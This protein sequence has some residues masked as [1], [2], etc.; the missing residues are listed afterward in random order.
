MGSHCSVPVDSPKTQEFDIYDDNNNSYDEE[1][2]DRPLIQDE[3]AETQLH[4]NNNNTKRVRTNAP[5]CG[6]VFDFHGFPHSSS[7]ID[8]SSFD[9]KS[10]IIIQQQLQ[11]TPATPKIPTPSSPPPSSPPPCPPSFV[12][13]CPGISST[14][15]QSK[16]PK[17]KAT[18]D[19]QQH[20]PN[21][22]NT[23]SDYRWHSNGSKSKTRHPSMC[24]YTLYFSHNLHKIA[25]TKRGPITADEEVY[26]RK[27]FNCAAK[28]KPSIKCEATKWEA[29]L[30]S[31]LHVEFQK[32]HN[33]PPPANPPL[34]SRVRERAVIQLE[35]GAKPT[36]VQRDMVLNSTDSKKDVAT[37]NQ[38]H[39][40]KH[41]LT[42][43]KDSGLC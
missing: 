43:V 6:D 29:Q 4:G 16:Q 27:Y 14:Q 15:Y 38:L 2:N 31:G 40:W 8:S 42:H 7:K 24:V 33:H 22:A 32:D 5:G 34:N 28:K 25:S 36:K 20:Y 39:Y 30:P 9:F 13:K 18:N 3:Y 21:N 26:E 11:S 23:V 35:A 19:N 1:G 10:S 37:K 41:L 17:E 12:S